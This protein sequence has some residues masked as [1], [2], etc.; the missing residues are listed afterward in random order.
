MWRPTWFVD[1][2][3]CRT[4]VVHSVGLQ[5]TFAYLYRKQICGRV[6]GVCVCEADTHPV[7]YHKRK[8]IGHSGYTSLCFRYFYFGNGHTLMLAL[9][10]LVDGAGR[11][12]DWLLV[13]TMFCSRKDFFY[14][15]I[16]NSA[17]HTHTRTPVRYLLWGWFSDR[18]S[19]DRVTGPRTLYGSHLFVLPLFSEKQTSFPSF[20]LAR[21]TALLSFTRLF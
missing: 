17:T 20:R 12:A 2:N 10:W 7:W 11:M 8:P 13:A 15:E 21:L 16:L 3:L 4:F 19:F 14:L 9:W 6:P 18:K 1:F 5:P